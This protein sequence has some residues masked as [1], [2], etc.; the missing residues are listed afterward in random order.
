MIS[1]FGSN[2]SVPWFRTLYSFLEGDQPSALA[3][4][5][6]PGPGLPY[7]GNVTQLYQPLGGWGNMAR[8][9][10]KPWEKSGEDDPSV[11]IFMDLGAKRIGEKTY[12]LWIYYKD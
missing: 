1:W 9:C 10:G 7:R 12:L 6:A 4:Q 5:P 8:K 11:S 3:V 2:V